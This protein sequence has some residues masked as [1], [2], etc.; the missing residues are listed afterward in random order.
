MFTDINERYTEKASKDINAVS[1]LIGQAVN[2]LR[3]KGYKL[4]DINIALTQEVDHA[5]YME[6]I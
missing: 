6:M 3:S 2:E 5:I 1:S 4:R